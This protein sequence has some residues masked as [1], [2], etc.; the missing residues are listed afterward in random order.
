MKKIALF[1]AVIMLLN[2]TAKAVV[3]AADVNKLDKLEYKLSYL[4]K[5]TDFVV[6]AGCKMLTLTAV[7]YVIFYV[8]SGHVAAGG[9]V[10]N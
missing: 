1:F 4:R 10:S 9:S 8:V 3:P 2:A 5:C 6:E 7:G